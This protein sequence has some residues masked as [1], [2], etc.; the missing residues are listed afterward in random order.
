[1]T[2]LHIPV[3]DPDDDVLSAAFKYAEAGWYVLPVKMSTKHPG[4]VV[5]NH[6]QDQSSRDPKMLAAW[7][8]GTSGLGIA[9]HQGRSGAVA[10][11]VDKPE[12][13]PDVLAAACV[14]TVHQSTRDNYADRGHYLFAMPP[15]RNIGNSNGALGKDWGEIRGKNGVVIVEPSHHEKAADGGRYQWVTTGE[16][17]ELPADVAELLPDAFDA[18][19]AAT[20]AQVLTF[21]A[22]HTAA[23]QAKLVNVWCAMFTRD[24]DAGGSRH[25]S[26]VTKLVGAMK[27]ARAGYFPAQ[28]AADTLE[29][30]FLA[31][32]GK[33]PKGKQGASRTG[34]IARN[35]WAGLLSWAIAQAQAADLDEVRARVEQ[36]VPRSTEQMPAVELPGFWDER[37]CLG[38]IRDFARARMCSPW[39]VL[40][41]TLARAIAT[42]PPYVVLPPTI[43]TEAS[44]NLFVALV[45]PSG[46]GKG[47][48]E[49]AARDAVD[50][51]EVFTA[52]V[53][54]GEGVAHLYSHWEKGGVVRDRS[55]VLFSTPEVDMLTALGSRQGA[56]L[57]STLRSAFSGEKLGFS[58]AS[59]EK[60]LP[61]DRHSYRMC[62]I[63][64]V[65]PERAGTLT[66]DADGGTPQRFVWMPTADPGIPDDTPAA[67]DP[68]TLVDQQW[69]RGNFPKRRIDI[70]AIAIDTIRDAHRAR[71]RG[72][73]D[74]LDGH[75]L[76]C[77][78]KASVALAILD[79]RQQ[80]SDDDWRLSGTVMAISEA[81]RTGVVARLAQ[82]AKVKTE[83]QGWADGVRADTANQSADEHAARRI[84]ARL[85]GKVVAAGELSRGDARNAIARRDRV[86]FDASLERLVA[87]GQVEVFDVEHGQRIKATGVSS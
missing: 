19:D 75:A 84:S 16:L 63:L 43:G 55:A 7:Y 36:K 8:A 77:R 41:V 40:G 51:G 66:A 11:D 29:G 56:T 31:A 71:L 53:G 45:G 14:R 58:Y 9:L 69:S 83:A 74:A 25:Q 85:L 67:P 26:M 42:V 44:L 70:P 82:Q 73:G 81:T 47:A 79:S 35:E 3:I 23:S 64:G 49:G 52:T 20:D 87:A 12:V 21:L 18:T 65:Q 50:M 38:H 4:S 39:A 5:G 46:M 17:L 72:E 1:V 30:M 13:M 33:A 22:E 60:T 59:R 62:L 80:V 57:L 15:G 24:V 86:H 32:V 54:S 37:K 34:A 48:A 61:L 2:A 10:V 28:L 6:W 76:L 68:A 27:E 78:L